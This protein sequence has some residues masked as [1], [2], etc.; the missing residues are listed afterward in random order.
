MDLLLSWLLISA[1]FARVSFLVRGGS[2]WE[3]DPKIERAI[4]ESVFGGSR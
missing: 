4:Y 2:G 3:P 1:I